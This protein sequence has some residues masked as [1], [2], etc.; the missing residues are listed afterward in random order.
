[1]PAPRLTFSPVISTKPL[2]TSR[3]RLKTPTE[4][5][6]C[7]LDSEDEENEHDSELEELFAGEDDDDDDDDQSSEVVPP[8]L[9][10]ASYAQ[11]LLYLEDVQAFLEHKGNTL[12][13]CEIMGFSSKITSLHCRS[14]VN[15]RQTSLR[16]FITPCDQELNT[17]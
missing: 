15:G 12:E 4:D 5:P 6:F 8:P 11:A 16:E 3:L 14:L 10:V 17:T 9:K 13:A 2:F 1:M 7:D